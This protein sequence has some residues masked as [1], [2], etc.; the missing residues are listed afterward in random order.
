[1]HDDK[2]RQ[3]MHRGMEL[4]TQQLPDDPFL[5]PRIL[6]LANRK[7]GPPMKKH[8]TGLIIA[9]ILMLLSVTALAV[10]L[11]VEDM[12]QQSFQKMNTT[13]YMNTGNDAT[14]AEIPLGEAVSMACDAITAKFGVTGAEIDAMGI[15]PTY[16]AHASIGGT[17]YPA[18][19]KIWFSSRRDVDLDYNWDDDLGQ[20]GE[21]RVYIN[22]ET[23]EITTCIWYTN[24]FWAKAQRVWDC[25]SYDEVYQRSGKPEFY[26][27]SIEM[28]HY[29]QQLLK[30][31][32]YDVVEES[33]KLHNM[34]RAAEMDLL[35]WKPAA[36]APGN[37]PQVIAAWQA[38]QDQ[39]GFDVQTLQKYAFV[40]I[41]PDWNSGYDDVCLHYSYELEWDLMDKGYLD[42]YSNVLHTHAL[43][44]GSYMVSFVPGTTQ[45]AAIT[46][47]PCSQ[48]HFFDEN[49]PD[50]PLLARLDWTAADLTEFDAAFTTLD[51]AIKRMKAAGCSYEQMDVAADDFLNRMGMG[52][53][54][55]E[56]YPL[57]PEEA[58]VAQWFA[59]ESEWDA[60]IVQPEL[61]YAEFTLAYGYDDRF[62]P[63]EVMIQL[64]L[65]GYRMPKEGGREACGEMSIA[66]AEAY[67]I[68]AIID[69]LG[70]DA[71]DQ[72]GDYTIS[73]HRSSLTD[74][75][76]EVNC[77]WD[78]YITDD[79]HEA[80]NGWRL[81][82]GEWADQIEEPYIQDIMDQGNG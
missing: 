51:R 40:A 18:E 27:Q 49:A 12:W 41:K 10:S 38:L 75:P 7:E 54:Y 60:R 21:Y 32:G 64:G 35:Y 3:L 46:H 13:G 82:W 55:A 14:E 52:V 44:F 53:F 25:G 65:H 9:I 78:V 17:E 74:N 80:R 73:V 26:M 77:R 6:T 79:P 39:R 31:K 59:D 33:E 2:L 45:V 22:A 57:A 29:W 30:D 50:G 15:Y 71:L 8:P 4:R 66:E 76:D 43:R 1:M 47:V 34:L 20:Y 72:L 56:F 69:Q 16:H 19:W 42:Q 81:S 70:Q 68:Q 28:Q 62:W 48:T 58:N 67:A 23:R 11:T 36:I 63:Q 5:A 61:N 24:D 37:D